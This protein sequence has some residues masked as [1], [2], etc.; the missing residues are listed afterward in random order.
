MPWSQIKWILFL[1]IKISSHPLVSYRVIY[2]HSHLSSFPC[3]NQR[4]CINLPLPVA[5]A[6]PAPA[7]GP[8][9]CLHTDAAQLWTD[10]SSCPQSHLF[11]WLSRASSTALALGWTLPSETARNRQWG[12]K[13]KKNTDHNMHSQATAVKADS[14]CD[15]FQQNMARFIGKTH[16]WIITPTHRYRSDVCICGELRGN[17][18]FHPNQQHT[19]T[20]SKCCCFFNVSHLL[21]S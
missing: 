10:R 7:E 1:Q 18:L 14:W 13:N 16:L 2:F 9:R 4:M 3:S 5:A 15:E 11:W 6:L 12:K 20:G 17:N 19:F 8:A 21:I